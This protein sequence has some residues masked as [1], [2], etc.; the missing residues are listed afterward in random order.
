M[1]NV[2]GGLLKRNET[3]LALFIILFGAVLTSINP[4]F[5]SFR[6]IASLLKNS[7]GTAILA[8]GFLLVILT[9]NIDVSFPA[10]AI[11]A[12]YI[13]ANVLMALDS[14]SLLLAFAIAIGIGLFY[15]AI[16]AFF[17]T[18]FNLPTLIVTLGTS[19]LFHGFLL[20]FVGTR[21][22]NIGQLPQP[23][24]DFGNADLF[25]IEMASGNPVGLSVFVGMLAL[26]LLVTWVILRFTLLGRGIYAIG[27]DI[28]AARRAGF[29]I[30]RVQYFIYMYVGLLAGVMGIMHISLINYGNPN[31]IVDTE[32]LRVI[33]AVVLGGALITGGKGTLTGTML[34]VLLIVTLQKNLVLIGLSSYWQQFFVGL[35][36][37]IGVTVTHVQE[38]IRTREKVVIV[39][40]H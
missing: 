40:S 36:I 39:R 18:K 22:I 16:N 29:N 21:S 8:I 34:G 28:E 5:I 32:L 11:S 24:K 35:I 17:V 13:S 37:V 4:E 20:E 1:R 31:Y 9:G 6:N 3:Y 15:G 38:K 26:A 12:Q 30:G 10:I 25:T 14:E 2:L 23:F 19:N 33:A 7:A 27:G